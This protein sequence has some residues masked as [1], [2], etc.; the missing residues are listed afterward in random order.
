MKVY[1]QIII[2]EILKTLCPSRSS[3]KIALPFLHNKPEICPA[4]T[5]RIFKKNSINSKFFFDKI[6]CHF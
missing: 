1:L 3:L 6:I 5:F 2:T 4:K